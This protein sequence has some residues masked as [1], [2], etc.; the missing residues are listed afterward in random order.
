MSLHLPDVLAY[1]FFIYLFTLGIA[2]TEKK[3]TIDGAR[4]IDGPNL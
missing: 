4:D 2:L 1:L 3:T